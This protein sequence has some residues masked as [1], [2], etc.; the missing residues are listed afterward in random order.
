MQYKHMVPYWSEVL[1][2]NQ[3][4]SPRLVPFMGGQGVTIAFDYRSS[5]EEPSVV[6]VPA[7]TVLETAIRDVAPSFEHFQREGIVEEE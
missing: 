7:E 1:V 6:A 4:Q 5:H 2:R 3:H